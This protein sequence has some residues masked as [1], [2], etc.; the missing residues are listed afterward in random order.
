MARTFRPRVRIGTVLPSTRLPPG[1]GY[2][3]GR[4]FP[5]WIRQLCLILET[6]LCQVAR[7]RIQSY[8]GNDWATVFSK[9]NYL[10]AHR[11]Y[12]H[13]MTGT[14]PLLELTVLAYT[15]TALDRAYSDRLNGTV[16]SRTNPSY[17]HHVHVTAMIPQV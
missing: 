4:R 17:S 12:C 9:H 2:E 15:L 7:Y 8:S 13:V 3:N 16:T 1:L 6:M 10:Q 14:N 5:P 11:R